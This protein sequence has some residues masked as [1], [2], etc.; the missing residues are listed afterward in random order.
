MNQPFY[1]SCGGGFKALGNFFNTVRNMID[2]MHMWYVNRGEPQLPEMAH[3]SR[4]GHLRDYIVV[5]DKSGALVPTDS[6]VQK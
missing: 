1:A 3:E 4:R 6:R 5:I 2:D